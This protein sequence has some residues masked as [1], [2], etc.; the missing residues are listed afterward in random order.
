MAGVKAPGIGAK[1]RIH[2][3]VRSDEVQAVA[4]YGQKG[5]VEVEKATANAAGWVTCGVNI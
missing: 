4:K 3:L 2:A 1:H 5:V